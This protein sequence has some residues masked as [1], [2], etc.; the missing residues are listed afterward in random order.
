MVTKTLVCEN[1]E[2]RYHN[3]DNTCGKRGKVTIGYDGCKSSEINLIYYIG[4]VFKK[5]HNANF[6]PNYLL[7][8]D[9]RFG[10][11]SICQIY[12]LKFFANRGIIGFAKE[13]GDSLT[14]DQIVNEPCNEEEINRLNDIVLKGK[15]RDFI[16]ASRSNS[17]EEENEP[18]VEEE[19]GWV[20]PS[21]EFFVYGWGKHEQ[22]AFEIIDSKYPGELNSGT[23]GDF[24]VNKG[25]ILID[26]P[27]QSCIEV[28]RNKN[29]RI[30]KAQREFMFDY[31]T[32]L[33]MLNRAKEFLEED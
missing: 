15:V 29:K 2:C 21:G 10:I 1:L 19:Y 28:T 9:L 11:Y 4:L 30:T 23:A 7:T 20:S 27:S 25:W 12:N 6:I 31:F 5:M 13:G 33:R 16:E 22:G 17:S 3:N 24:L 18:E 26:D 14:V 8:D 32:K